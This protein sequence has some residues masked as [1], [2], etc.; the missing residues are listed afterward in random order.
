[1]LTTLLWTVWINRT[2]LS[3]L[4]VGAC[5]VRRGAQ[6]VCKRL[7]IGVPA[8]CLLSDSAGVPFGGWAGGVVH[9]EGVLGC[10]WEAGGQEDLCWG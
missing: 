2:Q 5:P 7:C 8:P 3:Y 4:S 1:M 10:R 6:Y 9:W